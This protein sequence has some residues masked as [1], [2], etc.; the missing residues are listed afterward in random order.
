MALRLIVGISVLASVALAAQQP[1]RRQPPLV[2]RHVSVVDPA[3]GTV[4]ADTT[5][6]IDSGRITAVDTNATPPR[7]ATVVDE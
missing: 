1:E 3:A 7:G 2:I 4:A 5:V 6:V